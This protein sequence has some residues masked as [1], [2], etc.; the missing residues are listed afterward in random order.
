MKVFLA[1]AMSLQ[2]TDVL[3]RLKHSAELTK[4]NIAV[5]LVS[6]RPNSRNR[7]H[8]RMKSQFTPGPWKVVPCPVH[9]GKHPFHDHRWI[10]TDDSEVVMSE[11]VPND[12]HLSNGS[13]ICMMR[14]V[15]PRNAYLIAS[16]PDLLSA[17]ERLVHPMA[18]DED[19]EFAREVIRKA[20]GQ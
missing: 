16:A 9:H 12:W 13:A 10:M 15:D 2:L 17:L 1:F 8:L 20:K 11:R 4:K 19:L 18:D 5:S 6:E 14:D 3:I 7:K